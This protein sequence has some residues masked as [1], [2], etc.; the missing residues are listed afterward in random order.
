MAF[1]HRTQA[2]VRLSKHIE[3]DDGAAE[4][5]K[6]DL[7]NVCSKLPSPPAHLILRRER[8]KKQE[9]KL[10]CGHG[11]TIS[12]SFLLLDL[13]ATYV[14]RGRKREGDLWEIVQI[15]AEAVYLK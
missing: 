9:K 3:Q 14:L 15:L 2:P 13:T 6:K 10:M 5:K 8:N 4:M 11:K 1:Y 7:S 12:L